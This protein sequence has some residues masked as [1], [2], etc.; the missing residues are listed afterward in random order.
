MQVL[1]KFK[2]GNTNY[3]PLLYDN[4]LEEADLTKLYKRKIKTLNYVSQLDEI[5]ERELDELYQLVLDASTS[6]D[7]NISVKVMQQIT[8]LDKLVEQ[9]VGTYKDLS[10]SLEFLMDKYGQSRFDKT[11]QDANLRE[12]QS[13]LEE[14]K[15]K[16][17]NYKDTLSEKQKL[18]QINTYYLKRYQNLISLTQL[19]CIYI[20]IIIIIMVL[21]INGILGDNIK[22]ALMG[23]LGAICI[24][25]LGKKIVDF[26]FRNNIN[27]DEYDWPFNKNRDH[28][29]GEPITIGYG[30][31]DDDECDAANS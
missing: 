7:D 9:K 2:E 31:D 4:D 1:F 24:I 11:L 30:D 8:Y 16:R 13:K 17:K 5:Q 27:F 18:T 28:G 20:F 12:I 25:H 3:K 29:D 21:N 23:V 10:N 15:E 22:V 19:I 6:D 26:Y 14:I